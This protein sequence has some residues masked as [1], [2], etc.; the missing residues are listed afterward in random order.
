MFDPA[1]REYAVNIG[2]SVSSV[3]LKATVADS[4][5]TGKINSEDAVSGTAFSIPVIVGPNEIEIVVTAQ[6]GT[7]KTYIVTVT[8]AEASNADLSGLELDEGELS[9]A[10]DPAKTEYAVSVA[11]GIRSVELK[12]TVI[13]RLLMNAGLI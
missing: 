9:P 11:N 4:T 3:S 2:K 8:R 5:A 7:E 13:Q 6:D 1:K 12:A 10:F